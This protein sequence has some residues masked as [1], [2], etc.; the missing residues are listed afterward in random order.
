MGNSNPASIAVNSDGK[1]NVKLPAGPQHDSYRINLFVQ[2]YDDSN[3]ITVY[4]IATQVTVTVDTQVASNL[5]SDLTSG[6]SAVLAQIQNADMNVAINTMLT[7]SSV[8]S[9]A[10]QQVRSTN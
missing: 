1:A 7:I 2:I 6:S 10:A 3:A 4:H 5:A 8:V 9:Q